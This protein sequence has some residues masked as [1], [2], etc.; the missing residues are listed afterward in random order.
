EAEILRRS[1]SDPHWSASWERGW[2]IY[3]AD[4]VTTESGTGI[5]HIAPAFGEVDMALGL[6]EK[7]PFIQHVTMSGEF[8]PEVKDFAGQKVKPIENP[9]QA[10]IEIIKFLAGKGT[11][12]AKEKITHSYPHCWRCATPLLNYATSS[13]FVKVTDIKDKLVANNQQ[14]NWVPEN[15]KDGRFGNWLEG[16]RDW[17][18]S[19]TRYW[20]A[21]LPVWKCHQCDKREVVG[22]LDDIL[23]LQKSAGNKYWLMR[24]GEA[25]ANIGDTLSVS[26]T[27]PNHLTEK[28]KQEV[29]ESAQ[30]LK[31]GKIDLIISSDFIRIK[32]TSQLV[33]R[34]LG[35][36]LEQIIF[37]ERLR[38]I[39]PGSFA[40][41][42][43]GDYN[44]SF[45]ERI[46]RLN[47]RPDHGGE[48]FNDV[49]RR[50]MAVFYEI[51]QK[52]QNKNILIVTHGLPCFMIQATV[53]RWSERATTYRPY[54]KPSFNTGEVR[55]IDFA[56]LP[57]NENFELD[58]HRPFIDNVVFPCA[59][60]GEM[61]R[62]S[63]VFDCW[64]E[65][66]AMPY[67]QDHYPFDKDNF[68]PE[69]KKGWPAD[70]IAE[71]LDQTRG[72]FYSLIVLGTALFGVSP[73]KNVVVNG[74]VLAESGQKM[75]KS[76]QNYPELTM[77]VDR[78]GADA[79][80]FY[81]MSLPVVRA[82]DLNFSEKGVAEVQRK[83]VMRLQN[84]C[85][86]YETYAEAENKKL[87]IKSE[88]ITNVLD[89]WVLV[90]LGETIILVSEA[91]DRYELDRAL[92]PIDEF[93]E[94]LSTWYL[95]RSRDR[96][97][98]DDE[99]DKKNVS[100]VTRFVLLEMA[101]VLAPV[102]PF[103]AEDLWQKLRGEKDELSV[104]LT[105]WPVIDETWAFNN[106]AVVDEM[107]EAR[108]I[109][110]L[111]LEFRQ[112]MGL[113]VRQP[114]AEIMVK[115]MR[116]ADKPEYQEII[117]DELNI[118]KITFNERASDEVWLDNEITDDLKKEGRAR[119]FIRKLQEQRKKMG[120]VPS[121]I[122]SLSIETDEE[123]RLILRK[124]E[125][126]IKKTATIKNIDYA[127]AGATPSELKIIAENVEIVVDETLFKVNFYLTS[128][129]NGVSD[130]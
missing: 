43:W 47:G 113:K 73:F 123:G 93:I 25:E 54:P 63:D 101:K 107:A 46:N 74:M 89:K 42:T 98:S 41:K 37:D 2:Q 77:V 111:G 110:S 76:L 36:K 23:R 92:R 44:D 100:A 24:H 115:N 58:I 21:P 51:D 27:D 49:R 128:A 120:L 11:L 22:S 102:T 125:P 50:A 52:Y 7:L 94:D 104:H 64:F 122:V 29:K 67:A 103:L 8:K 90:R 35:L 88:E 48:N 19:R 60:G 78:Y 105:A 119:E 118:K 95:R 34:E 75:S 12:Y 126:E 69:Q 109:V 40:G 121:D 129:K 3:P 65:S 70:F 66:G 16:A 59:C 116:L 61:K 82:E 56:P 85:T 87:S 15:I 117:K 39:S 14:V 30:K 86:F 33:A 53:D 99:N 68:D 83:I 80:R 79:L 127:I 26:P 17:A 13:W 45:G 32:E 72:W 20:G 91:L 57:H 5:V 130:L 71:G 18:I 9:Q 10:D 97:K 31:E 55:A 114:L 4:F 112:S 84:V 38:E 106:P 62:I 124:F 1:A 96:F 81:M 28:G 6:K 108:K